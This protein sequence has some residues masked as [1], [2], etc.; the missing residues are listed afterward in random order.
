M[1]PATVAMLIDGFI[2][3]GMRS[4]EIA[5]KLN[6]GEEITEE[7][8]RLKETFNEALDRMREEKEARDGGK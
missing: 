2:V 5:G 1:E 7:D 6:R 8:L 4:L 3:V